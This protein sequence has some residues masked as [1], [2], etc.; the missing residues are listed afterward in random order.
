MLAETSYGSDGDFSF[1]GLV[2]RYNSDLANNLGNLA[3]RAATVVGKKCDG[4]GP[5]PGQTPLAEAAANAV[6]GATSGWDAVAPSRALDATWGL[7]KATNAYLETNE[8]WKSEPGAEVNAVMGDALEALRIIT[9]LAS[10]A[11]P[12]TSELIWQRLGLSGSVTDQRIPS[13]VEWGGYTGGA[14][15]EKGTPLFPRIAS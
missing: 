5:A 15:V 1:E 3:A 14:P 2:G 11:V 4:V 12:Q 13:D 6:A 9:I 8:P 7:I 10:P